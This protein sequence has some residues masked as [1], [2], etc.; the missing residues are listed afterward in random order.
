MCQ[1][2]EK[3]GTDVGRL[4]QK[5]NRCDTETEFRLV[6]CNKKNIKNVNSLQKALA[7]RYK[8]HYNEINNTQIRGV[9][10]NLGIFDN[11][12]GLMSRIKGEAFFAVITDRRLYGAEGRSGYPDRAASGAAVD[13]ETDR[14]RSGTL[15]GSYR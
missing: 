7:F 4:F 12:D 2:S 3:Y 15:G 14:I 9:E 13:S 5:I 8:M 6:K 11:S 1:K 10:M